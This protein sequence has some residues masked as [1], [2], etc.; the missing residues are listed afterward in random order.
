MNK[1][2]LYQRSNDL[3]RRDAKEI[4]DEFTP[5]MRWRSEGHDSLMDIG[6]GIADVT[7]DYILPILPM[8]YSRLVGIDIS[9]QMLQYARIHYGHHKITF[10]NTDIGA[11]LN[12][13]YVNG[14][15]KRVDHITSF[16]CL[17]WVPNQIKAL[18]FETERSYTTTSTC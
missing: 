6:C 9:D 17:H 1:A 12:K 10:D 13:Y 11:D 4:I 3:Q 7:I 5:L 8:N 16:Y 2:A 15:R 14:G 18:K